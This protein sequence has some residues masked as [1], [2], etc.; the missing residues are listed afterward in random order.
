MEVIQIDFEYKL[1]Q[2]HCFLFNLFLQAVCPEG[3]QE[4]AEDA[5]TKVRSWC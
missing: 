3:D 2:C 4:P 1:W 5:E